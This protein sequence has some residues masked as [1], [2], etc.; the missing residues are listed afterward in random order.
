MALTLDQLREQFQDRGLKFTSQRIAIYE[1]LAAS[2]EHPSVDDLYSLVKKN[3]PTLSMNTVYNTLETL[4]EIGIA[5]E[6][7]L[8]HDKARYDANQSPHHHLVCLKCRRIEDIYDDTL[9]DL[10]L[11][12][13]TQNQYQIVGHRV[14]FHGYCQNCKN[15]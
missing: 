3:H 4:K 6:V 10:V 11:S 2:K 5:N 7:S 13:E 12:G 9:N 14:E 8:F 15:P 1:A